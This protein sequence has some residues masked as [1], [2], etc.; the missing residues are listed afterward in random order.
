MNKYRRICAD[1]MRIRIQGN[2]EEAV[3]LLLQKL[4]ERGALEPA[5]TPDGPKSLSG[6]KPARNIREAKILV[7]GGRGIGSKAFITELQKLAD[8]LGGMVS[9]SRANVAAGWADRSLQ[10]GQTGKYVTPDIYI[11]CGIAG[12]DQHLAGM[13]D[14]GYIIAINKNSYAPIFS[15]ADLGIVGDVRVIVPG[16]IEAIGRRNNAS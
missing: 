6:E 11:A 16:L 15:V 9:S 3:K 10:V 2:D 5:E 13:I 4:E 1:R 8:L 14:S 12:M 7:S